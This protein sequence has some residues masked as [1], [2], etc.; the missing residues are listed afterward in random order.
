MN[1]KGLELTIPAHRPSRAGMVPAL[2]ENVVSLLLRLLALPIL[3]A[4]LVVVCLS[5]Q[6]T[7]SSLHIPLDLLAEKGFGQV[8]LYLLLLACIFLFLGITGA[9]RNLPALRHSYLFRAHRPRFL[10]T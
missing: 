3:A 9:L 7:A 10:Y 1:S 5:I 4:V 8:L 6:L 2:L